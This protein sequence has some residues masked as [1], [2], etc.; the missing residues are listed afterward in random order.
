MQSATNIVILGPK[1]DYDLPRRKYEQEE[2]IEHYVSESRCLSGIGGSHGPLKEILK[3]TIERRYNEEIPAFQDFSHTSQ[4]SLPRVSSAFHSDDE[5]RHQQEKG[6]AVEMRLLCKHQPEFKLKLEISQVVTAAHFSVN[7]RISSL[8]EIRNWLSSSSQPLS[9]TVPKTCLRPS[10]NLDMSRA[11]IDSYGYDVHEVHTSEGGAR[12]VQTHGTGLING[13]GSRIQQTERSLDQERVH[14][15]GGVEH[16]RTTLIQERSEDSR[17]EMTPSAIRKEVAFLN[18]S[19]STVGIGS[20][21]RQAVYTLPSPTANERQISRRIASDVGITRKNSY[22][23]MQIGQQDDSAEVYAPRS[24]A[25]LMAG[26][27]GSCFQSSDQT[28]TPMGHITQF[29][30]KITSR[31]RNTTWTP[32]SVCLLLLFIL[33]VTLFFIL[34]GIVLNALFGSFSTGTILLYPPICEECR[35]RAPNGQYRQAPSEL[36]V[37]FRGSSQVRFEL[38]GK[39]PFRSSSLTVIDFK[40]NYVAVADH[41]LADIS[42]KHSTCFLMPLDHSAIPSISTLRDALSSV[43]SEIHSEYGWQEYWQYHAEP[44]DTSSAEHKF[45]DKIGDCIGAKWYI[46][47]HTVYTRDSICSNCYDFCLPDYAI[48]RLHKYEDDMTIGIRRLNCLRLYVPEWAKY[49]VKTD[50][51]GG[52]WFYPHLLSNTS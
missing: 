3:E 52:R 43:K 28:L 44:I 51:E 45:T 31:V 34:L 47:K 50:N 5:Q 11:N 13:E 38:N 6:T 2:I 10:G 39:A 4:N 24:D 9:S 37:N 18:S 1:M 49:Q 14:G 8:K 27:A 32:H 35:Q 17:A 21:Q 19:R 26:F 20:D 16:H 40:T 33:L 23:C 25:S 12:I 30:R 22:K 46:L 42:G 41:A 15:Y 29:W 7:L 36:H 48:Q